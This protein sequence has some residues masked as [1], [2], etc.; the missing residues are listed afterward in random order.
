MKQNVDYELIPDDDEGWNFRILTGDFVETVFNFGVLQVSDD[1][2][3]LKYNTQVISTPNDDLDDENEEWQNVSGQILI[4]I[5]EEM[6]VKDELGTNNPK[7]RT[8]K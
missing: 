8:N 5:L 7:E 3:Y 2:E 6:M 4:D 1:G